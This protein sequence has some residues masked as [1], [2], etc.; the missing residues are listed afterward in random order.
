[1][2][3]ALQCWHVWGPY[4]DSNEN[5]YDDYVL[6]PD[7]WGEERVQNTLIARAAADDDTALAEYLRRPP[8][9]KRSR[10]GWLRV[11]CSYPIP[12]PMRSTVRL[13][14]VVIVI[15][16]RGHRMRDAIP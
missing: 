8:T 16:F 9:F 15:L 3:R 13:A 10:T 11:R 6:M 2:S 1:M 14:N 12:P 4:P 7:G 5:H